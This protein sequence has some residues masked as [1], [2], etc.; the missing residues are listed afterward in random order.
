MGR[1]FGVIGRC[2]FLWL[3]FWFWTGV[4]IGAGSFIETISEVDAVWFIRERAFV[5]VVLND[6]D[7][8]KQDAEDENADGEDTDDDGELDLAWDVVNDFAEWVFGETADDEGETFFNVHRQEEADAADDHGCFIVA[9][10]GWDEQNE[11]YDHA[12]DEEHHQ[13]HKFVVAV[14]AEEEIG[15]SDLVPHPC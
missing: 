7:H 10:F 9:E 4:Y 5:V 8:L 2:F 13:W 1:S 6:G 15:Q 11:G 3:W 12:N 14:I